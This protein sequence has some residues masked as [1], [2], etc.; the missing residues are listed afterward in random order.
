M[1]RIH[2]P[3]SLK[4]GKGIQGVGL[5]KIKRRRVGKQYVRPPFAIVLPTIYNLGRRLGNNAE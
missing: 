1:Q 2:L 4:D 5:L 3:P